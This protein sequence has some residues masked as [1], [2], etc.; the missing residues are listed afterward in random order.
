MAH[1]CEAHYKANVLWWN[2][3]IHLLCEKKVTKD[4]QSVLAKRNRIACLKAAAL[5]E[6]IFY[7]KNKKIKEEK[8]R[9]TSYFSLM[10]LVITC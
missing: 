1:T 2:S 3:L 5:L 6:V 7:L 9:N 4:G 10:F 8:C